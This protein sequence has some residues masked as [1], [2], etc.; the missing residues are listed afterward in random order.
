MDEL[1]KLSPNT[2]F[3]VSESSMFERIRN[4]LSN[5]HQISSTWH[6]LCYLSNRDYD[7]IIFTSN[8]KS[9]ADFI[10][11]TYG[12]DNAS[13]IV[14]EIFNINC[15]YDIEVNEVYLE[16]YNDLY[17]TIRVYERCGE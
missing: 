16:E 3:H 13:N 8:E 17:F 4:N 5:K 11:K 2:V 1:L 6:D 9:V 7:N 15:D 10:E 12:K 14:R